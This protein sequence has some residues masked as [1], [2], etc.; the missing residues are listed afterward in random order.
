MQ[1]AK[2]LG[3]IK[4]ELCKQ[5]EGC[6]DTC[7]LI[8]P[9]A[10]GGG[11][12]MYSTRP[13][14]EIPQPILV[15]SM[16][17]ASIQDCCLLCSQT[18]PYHDVRVCLAQSDVRHGQHTGHVSV[19]RIQPD[20]IKDAHG[21]QMLIT[22]PEKDR[23]FSLGVDAFARILHACDRQLVGRS[24]ACVADACGM[25]CSVALPCARAVVLLRCPTG[26]HLQ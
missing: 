8:T 25:H 7:L 2:K 6:K 15:V 3:C 19:K 11:A 24:R 16:T 14:I 22:T 18:G 12:L 1:A 20:V 4:T 13:E 10:E 21:L 26:L 5:G 23:I 9:I 17:R